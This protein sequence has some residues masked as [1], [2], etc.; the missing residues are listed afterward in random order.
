[1]GFLACEG[2]SPLR[3]R[4]LVVVGFGYRS[5]LQQSHEFELILTIRTIQ[6]YY[7]KTNFR[8]ISLTKLS[9]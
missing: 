9:F 2:L 7:E 4:P 5:L 3:E 6:S 1:M 8:R